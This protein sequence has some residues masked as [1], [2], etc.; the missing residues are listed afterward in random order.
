[1][2]QQDACRMIQRQVL[3]VG[4]MTRAGNHSFRATGITVLPEGGWQQAE[5]RHCR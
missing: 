4:I 1:M 5:Q 2:Y 3:K